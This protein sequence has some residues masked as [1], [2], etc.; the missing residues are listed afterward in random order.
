MVG[1]AHPTSLQTAAGQEP[2]SP[3]EFADKYG[4]KNDPSKVVL[5]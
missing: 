5:P 4:W 2:L 1:N 3:K